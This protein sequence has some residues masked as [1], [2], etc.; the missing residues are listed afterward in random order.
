ML[1]DLQNKIKALRDFDWGY[2]MEKVI[3][4]KSEVIAD[5]QAEQWAKGQAANGSD[6]LP[7][8]A[9]FTIEEKKKKSGLAGVYDHVTFYDTGEL[10]KSLQGE[11]ANMQYDITSSNFKFGKAVKRS[12]ER[13]VGLTD[14]N[15]ERF[16]DEI[17]LPGVRKVFE[18]K[19]GFS[20]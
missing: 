4:D 5:F 20:F 1:D 16:A 9:E 6:I 2:E 15:K 11:V 17:T 3:K 18:E 8:Y 12:G 13:I 10:Y 14:V 19:T 7:Q